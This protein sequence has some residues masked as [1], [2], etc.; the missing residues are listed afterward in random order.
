VLGFLGPGVDV[1]QLDLAFP[2]GELRRPALELTTPIAP[3]AL[4]AARL[5]AHLPAFAPPP[6]HGGLPTTPEP[7]LLPGPDLALATTPQPRSLTLPACAVRAV[8]A[9]MHARVKADLAFMR[10]RPLLRRGIAAHRLPE[11]QAAY[12]TKRLA[13]SRRIGVRLIKL[14]A[15]FPDLELE[16][17]RPVAYRPED[18]AI[19]FHLPARPVPPSTI[20][21]ARHANTGEPLQGR[22][23][24]D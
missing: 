17:G 5:V 4:L 7:A 18:D 1:Q 21:I 14:V 11:D 3:V 23:Y 12:W 13:D 8:E 24:R 10:G 16:E 19:A 6:V 15:V 9:P 20:V 22:F 2:G